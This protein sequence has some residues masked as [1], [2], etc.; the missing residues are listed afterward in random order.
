MAFQSV[1][2]YPGQMY[3]IKNR[4]IAPL[5]LAFMLLTLQFNNKIQEGKFSSLWLH[6]QALYWTVLILLCV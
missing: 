1:D 3:R 4:K 2:M 5:H 6:Y